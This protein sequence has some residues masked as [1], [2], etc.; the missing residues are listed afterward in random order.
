MNIRFPQLIALILMLLI[1]LQ[2]VAVTRMSFCKNLLKA[3][4]E[5]KNVSSITCH[6]D[7]A[8]VFHTQ[9]NKQD[10][11]DKVAC[12]I[13]CATL[14]SNLGAMTAIESN[15][16]PLTFPSATLSIRILHQS[17]A[18]ITLPSLQRPPISLS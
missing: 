15:I 4:V 17:Y 7:A 2:S 11:N 5:E 12:K 16:Y 6:Q 1:S 3:N 8:G 13:V 9:H 18:S 14:C 10:C